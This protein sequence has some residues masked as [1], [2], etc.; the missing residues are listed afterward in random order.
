MNTAK[1]ITL[2]KNAGFIVE[3]IENS[4]NILIS[5]SNRIVD[6]IEAQMVLGDRRNAMRRIGNKVMIAPLTIKA[7]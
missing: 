5:L 1:M 7:R 4:S 2:F 6:T 3:T